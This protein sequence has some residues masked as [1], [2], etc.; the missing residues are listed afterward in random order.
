MTDD[1]NQIAQLWAAIEGIK[2]NPPLLDH[3]HNGFDVSPVRYADLTEKPAMVHPGVI[4]GSRDCSVASGAVNY[5]HGYSTTPNWVELHASWGYTI[6]GSTFSPAYQSVGYF[7][8][9]GT[10]KC[11]YTG[12]QGGIASHAIAH[13]ART[14]D[15]VYIYDLNLG[16]GG[17]QSGVI[18]VN[19]TNIVIT[20]T[21]TATPSVVADLIFFFGV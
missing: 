4:T 10:N 19:S 21:K 8:T 5:A 7:I 11:T 2:N 9:G 3:R 17:I 15:A 14:S 20:W 13:G 18:T 1:S 16:T 6:G 12:E